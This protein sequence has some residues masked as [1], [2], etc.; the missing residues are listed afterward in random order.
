MKSCDKCNHCE[1]AKISTHRY[2]CTNGHGFF[3]LPTFKALFCPDYLP[4]YK[5]MGMTKKEY[6]EWKKDRKKYLLDRDTWKKEQKEKNEN[7]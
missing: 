7:K 6:R 1:Y 5:K 3:D 2:H 4:D